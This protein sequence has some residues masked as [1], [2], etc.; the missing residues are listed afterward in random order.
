MADILVTF[1]AAAYTVSE[2]ET[3]VEGCV[4]TS[5]T[6]D[7]GQTI[8]VFISTEDGTAMG[9]TILNREGIPYSRKL[10]LIL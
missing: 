8:V 3:T 9:M 5:A 4:V 2:G 6:P 10:W 1:E 7:P